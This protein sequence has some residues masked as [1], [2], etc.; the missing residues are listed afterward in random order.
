M[1]TYKLKLDKD[2]QYYWI[3]KSDKNGETIAKSSESYTTKQ[4]ALSSIAWTRNNAK[5]AKLEDL[6]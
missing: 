3:L 5:E 6:T 1:A 4:N 2:N